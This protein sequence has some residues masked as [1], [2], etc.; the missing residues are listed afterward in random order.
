ML[1]RVSVCSRGG[2]GGGIGTQPLGGHPLT[3]LVYPLARIGVAPSLQERIC[4]AG[5]SLLR[6]R[7][8]TFLFEDTF[9]LGHKQS[10]ITL[11]L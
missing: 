7:R 9:T 3:D 11:A 2:G 1:L 8:K 6:S 4:G 10:D 5:G